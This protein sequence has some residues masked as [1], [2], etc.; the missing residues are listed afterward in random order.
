MSFD[1]NYTSRYTIFIR[2]ALYKKVTK[3]EMF[4]S[5]RKI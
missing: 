3:G 4:Q 1:K 2:L 5:D